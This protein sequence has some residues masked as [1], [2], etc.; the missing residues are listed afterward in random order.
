[1]S[2]L[3]FFNDP[4]SYKNI[5]MMFGQMGAGMPTP[6]ASIGGAA[7]NYLGSQ[8]Y[9]NIANQQAGIPSNPHEIKITWP[10]VPQVQ[11]QTQTQAP[12][13]QQTP[14]PQQPQAQAPAAQPMAQPM[15]QNQMLAQ[16]IGT[17]AQTHPF[18]RT[19]PSWE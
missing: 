8:K 15:A 12:Q 3:D 14:Q 7:A 9:T 13:P 16:M 18:F 19:L 10:K 4:Q 6:F 1:M 2:W 5:G 17:G 11:D